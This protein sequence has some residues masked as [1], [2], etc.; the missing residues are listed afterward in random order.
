MNED[1]LM[2]ALN[3]LLLS[4]GP[5]QLA[6]SIPGTGAATEGK[7]RRSNH[8]VANFQKIPPK[9]HSGAKPPR[10]FRN[11]PPLGLAGELLLGGVSRSSWTSFL[12]R[13]LGDLGCRR[14]VPQWRTIRMVWFGIWLPKEED[15]DTRF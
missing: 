12:L 13:S 6:R 15:A 9:N 10:G 2:E 4:A 11:R 1:A 5:N 3:D 14:Q 7:F 8:R